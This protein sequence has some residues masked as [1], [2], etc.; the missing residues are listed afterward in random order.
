EHLG[1]PGYICERLFQDIVFLVCQSFVTV[2]KSSIVLAISIAAPIKPITAASCGNNWCSN[3]CC[4]RRR[5]CVSESSCSSPAKST[6]FVECSSKPASTQSR[7]S[8]GRTWPEPATTEHCSDM[9][10]RAAFER[11]RSHPAVAC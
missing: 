10:P 7:L 4:N 3:S 5:P 6:G 1:Y 8:L 2:A 11:P 9:E